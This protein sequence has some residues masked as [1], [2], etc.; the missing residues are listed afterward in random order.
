[1][2]LSGL[3]AGIA[4]FAVLEI[5]NN[6][7]TYEQSI[8]PGENAFSSV[9]QTT[10][11]WQ[12][13]IGALICVAVAFLYQ[14]SRFGRM[15]RATREDPAAAAAAGI[16]IYR[17]RLLAFALSGGLAGFAG[18]IYV[19]LL[20]LQAGPLSRSHVH[21][22]RDARRRR[23]RQPARRG[24][25]RAGGER[26]LLLLLGGDEQRRRLRLAPDG[27][28]GN[29]GDRARRAD[30]GRARPPARPASPAAASSPCRGGVAPWPTSRKR[31]P[32]HEVQHLHA[33]SR[34][35]PGKPYDRLYGEV[36]EQIENADRLGYEAYAAIEHLFF[37]KF[38]ASA[39][40]FGLF[41]MAAARTRRINF[42]T[43]LH[44]L[45]YHNPLVLAAMIH[46][47]SLLTG[48]RYEFG[49]GRGHGWIPL[50][51]GMPLDE[52][53]RPRYEEALDL[54]VEALHS[55]VVSFHGRVLERRRTAR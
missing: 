53:S 14:R 18:G 13:A 31:G 20:P 9:P 36:L 12:A 47:F 42:R 44:I 37:P 26:P 28:V 41:G 40:V 52:T 29:G 11:I 21:H 4:T 50:P 35:G 48:G 2:R 27:P 38:S 23:L 46:E 54:F 32:R 25:R 15:L 33:S 24:R 49:V 3:A 10:G 5:T 1:M 39:N 34:A 45:P 22:A 43:M 8:G 55:D 7:L 51:A 19:H 16:S 6:V 30:G 17:Q